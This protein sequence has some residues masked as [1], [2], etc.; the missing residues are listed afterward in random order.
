MKCMYQYKCK[1]CGKETERL[2]K[3]EEQGPVC[4]KPEHGPMEKQIS[5]PAFTFVRGHGTS[6][7]HTWRIAK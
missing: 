4:E 7:G 5:T 6:G 1:T 3:R 2:Q